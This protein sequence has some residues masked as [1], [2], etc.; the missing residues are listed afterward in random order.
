MLLPPTTGPRKASGLA[1]H[2]GFPYQ[3]IFKF[4]IPV[5]K[6]LTVKITDSFNYIQGNL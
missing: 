5:H 1:R 4:D 6:S 3:D 2:K